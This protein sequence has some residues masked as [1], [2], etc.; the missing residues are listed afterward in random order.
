MLNNILMSSVI[1]WENNLHN[2]KAKNEK[3]TY[4]FATDVLLSNKTFSKNFTTINDAKNIEM[5]IS[6]DNHIYELITKSNV[7]IYFDID[8]LELT[9]EQTDNFLKDFVKI[10]NS[11]LKIH[12]T[13]SDIIV[14][15]ND[16]KNKKTGEYSDNIHSLHIIIPSYTMKKKQQKLFA[17]Y[18]NDKYDE[19]L[20]K[21]TS[22]D[23]FDTAVYNSNNQFRMIN[24]SKLS[25]KIK[26][27][28]YNN[29][30]INSVYIK[31]SR[32]DY[33]YKAT[34]I[35][36]LTPINPFKQFTKNKQLKE[37]ADDELVNFILTNDSIDSK[38]LMNKS[39]IWKL[40]TRLIM[41]HTILYDINKWC[42]TSAVVAS[43]S[44]FTAERNKEFVELIK[45][46]ETFAETYSLYKIIN[47]YSDKYNVYSQNQNIQYHTKEFLEEHF[48]DSDDIIE[49][50]LL[51]RNGN[52]KLK[53]KNKKMKNKVA[54][55]INLKTGFIVCSGCRVYN[56][57][58]DNIPVANE[59]LF[60]S[61][62]DIDGAKVKLIDFINNTN[63]SVMVLK[64]RWGT[65]KTY[66]I[67]NA[68]ISHYE[69]NFKILMVTESN[70]LNSKLC[71][72][73]GFVSHQDDSYKNPNT[74]YR[75]DK[76]VCS[77][78]SLYRLDKADYDIVIVDEIQSVLNAYSSSGT[79]KNLP[80]NLKAYNMYDLL[81]QKIKDS[82]KSLLCDADIQQNY[83]EALT[84]TIG[85]DNMTIVKNT[86][87]A[88]SNYIIDIYTDYKEILIELTKKILHTDSKIAIASASRAKIDEYVVDI[89]KQLREKM[90]IGDVTK[91][92]AVISS[93]GV[94]LYNNGI[95]HLATIDKQET[96]KNI[97]KFVIDNDVDL[98]F[99]SPTIKT[100]ISFNTKDYFDYTFAFGECNSIV[101][102][103][104]LQMLFRVRNL[105]QKYI[106]VYLKESQF[107]C[108]KNSNLT[109]TLYLQK[110]KNN[111]FKKLTNDIDIYDDECS[112]EYKKIQTINLNV[113]QNTK[114]NY[115]QN[116]IALLKYHNLEYHYSLPRDYYEE[117]VV[118]DLADAK[119]VLQDREYNEWM[120]IS[121]MDIKLF[122]EM[123]KD[124]GDNKLKWDD[125][126]DEDKHSYSKTKQLY[127]IH[128]IKEN[129]IEDFYL[130][131]ETEPKT[132]INTEAQNNLEICNNRHFFCKYIYKKKF[133]DIDF[134]RNIYCDKSVINVDYNQE[135]EKQNINNK[136]TIRELIGMFGLFEENNI[137]KTKTLTNQEFKNILIANTETIH[138]WFAM[139]NVKNKKATFQADN[140]CHVKQIKHFVKSHL[141]KIDI[142]LKYV[143][144]KNTN[145]ESKSSNTKAGR[146]TF[147]QTKQF[148]IYNENRD[149]TITPSASIKHIPNQSVPFPK[150]T[151][152]NNKMVYIEKNKSTE[153]LDD[154]KVKKLQN[155]IDAGDTL[156]KRIMKKYL[157]SKIVQEYKQYT[158]PDDINEMIK[159]TPF[160]NAGFNMKQNVNG[161]ITL[162]YTDCDIANNK[163]SLKEYKMNT[164]SHTKQDYIM[165]NTRK[166]TK[167][168]LYKND[169][170]MVK[171]YT[172]I[173]SK[174]VQSFISKKVHYLKAVNNVKTEE[175]LVILIYI[176][177]KII[178]EGISTI[179][180]K[181]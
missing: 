25:N 60:E 110:I 52:H 93:V 96:L 155:Q 15:C 164:N 47:T 64:S 34:E 89:N 173:I 4:I 134:V 106:Y 146:M 10:I 108:G 27:I 80:N 37:L 88:F 167:L 66:H 117:G 157:Y 125:I 119:L 22:N 129:N 21:Y 111:V 153:L 171:P 150:I 51:Y 14:M 130:T 31:K 76:V 81:L 95:E 2:V 40:M 162:D 86:Q 1:N 118:V 26:L 24:Q 18:L 175:D 72:D 178:V 181:S 143:D 84:E 136:L 65:G 74:L 135:D 13:L 28:D 144:G 103:E 83:I 90:I 62:K 115:N 112:D 43:N 12:L 149:L 131:D 166:R 107:F 68:L 91:T 127:I 116:I 67:I 30:S 7:K 128:N 138:K 54:F 92:I 120:D 46:E 97:D 38:K 169:E 161:N 6:N 151:K 132:I 145:Y 94:T 156:A 152:I 142:Q 113:L 85:K 42:E 180:C 82:K 109:E 50:I 3:H 139:I 154:N 100:G 45:D 55:E 158:E 33:V 63:K 170:N 8:N 11:E 44:R 71:E 39:R 174:K 19:F 58:C 23:V 29:S 57:Y 41:K 177:R 49:K 77:V 48:E 59:T 53:I 5:V 141:S 114:Y 176:Y 124:I 9:R 122:F 56:M 147:K 163:I 179:S 159:D 102:C 140:I 99:Y 101:F 17:N 87:V 73:Y 98:L 165:T 126:D 104:F 36:F 160:Y 133:N 172:S 137:F 75:N 16:K 148:I 61:V 78:Q 70:A 79:F 123:K 168:Y 32:I 35:E 69:S 121:I 20:E 105:K